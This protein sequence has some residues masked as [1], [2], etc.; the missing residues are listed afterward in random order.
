MTTQIL[1][2][3]FLK[4]C[5][6][7]DSD[8]GIFTWR[9]RAANRLKVGD[10]AGCIDSTTGYIRIKVNGSMYAAHRVAWLY[11]H[12]NFPP[13]QIDH[14]NGIRDDNRIKNLRAVSHQE[15]GR[16]QSKPKDNKSGVVGVSWRKKDQKWQAQI[17]VNGKIKHLG[18]FADFVEAVTVRKQA[19]KR[20][21]FHE[22]HGKDLAA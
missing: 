1:T 18:H 5:L 14:I 21:G 15:N 8:T 12:G 7:Y 16:N 9:V 10:V 19:E 22:N 17:Y 11:A 2:Q 13:E 20:Y 3:E 6:H 4:E